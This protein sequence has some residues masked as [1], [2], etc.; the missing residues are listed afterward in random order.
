[1]KS[2]S[3]IS[4]HSGMDYSPNNTFLQLKQEISGWPSECGDAMRL[5]L[6]NEGIWEN[7]KKLG[8]VILDRNNI[9]RNPGLRSIAKLCLNSFWGKFGQRTNLPNTEIVKSYL[10][11]TL[12]ES[13]TWDNWYIIF[14][15]WRS[16]IYFVAATQR[17]DRG[18]PN[19]E[20]RN[21]DKYDSVSD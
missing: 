8:V 10:R 14:C 15:Q 1:M 6:R 13:G 18:F 16:N 2:G 4:I 11:L 20:R 17:G 12:L 21:R 5:R 3:T 7:T 19:N 9:A